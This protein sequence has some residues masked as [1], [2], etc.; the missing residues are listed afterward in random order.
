M[1]TTT[2]SAG[3]PL[4]AAHQP[5]MDKNRVVLVM[6]VQLHEHRMQQ[7]EAM[8]DNLENAFHYLSGQGLRAQE[9]QIES[10]GLGNLLIQ[11]LSRRGV[12]TQPLPTPCKPFVDDHRLAKT[13][14][15]HEPQQ[16]DGSLAQ[17]PRQ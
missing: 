14:A 11:L 5:H 7:I 9:I 17:A 4:L 1:S 12:A 6:N 8:T 10:H 15:S 2:K 13:Y 3:Q 16:P